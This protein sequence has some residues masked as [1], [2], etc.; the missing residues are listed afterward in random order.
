MQESC[1]MNLICWFDVVVFWRWMPVV[2]EG[3]PVNT[4]ETS[5][6]VAV[7]PQ[8]RGRLRML[9][10][11]DV[12]LD[13][14]GYRVVVRGTT[15]HLPRKEFV[16]LRQLMENAGRVV[17]R[18]ALLDNAWGSDRTAEARCYLPVHIRRIRKRIESDADRPTRIR[19]VRN[20]GYV[21]DL[22]RHD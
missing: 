15:V 19:T 20:V 22:P 3:Q 5:R 1:G 12:E 8:T 10:V 13:L 4:S 6:Y 18:R 11:G 9:K 7:D 17:M 21:Y 16:I 2:S 14:D